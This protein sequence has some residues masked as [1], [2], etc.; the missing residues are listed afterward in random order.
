MKNDGTFLVRLPKEDLERF[1]EV[2]KKKA[3]N[4]SELLRQWIKKFIEEESQ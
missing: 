4:R 1:N 3:L 2:L